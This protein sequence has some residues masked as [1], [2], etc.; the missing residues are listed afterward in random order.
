MTYLQELLATACTELFGVN[1][2][3]QLTRPEEQFG[4]FA[5]NVALQLAKELKQPPRQVAEQLKAYVDEHHN[6]SVAKVEVAGPGFLNVFMADEH[7][8]EVL[9]QATSATFGHNNE[10]RN[11]VV[12]AEYS[13]PN[14][15]KVLHA[16]HL[17]TTI[18]G[19]AIASL[20]QNAGAKVHRLNY[21]GDVGR[22]V[23]ITM[24]AIIQFLEG[25]HP[26]KLKTVPAD[27]RLEWLSA[28]YVEGNN[29]YEDDPAAKVAITDYNK[30]V[31]GLHTHND[32]QS[33]FAQIYWTCREW[34]YQGFDKLYEQLRVNP[35]EKY[36]PE[37][38]V[39]P[40]GVEMVEKG[41]KEG[42]F[43]KSE[44]AVVFKGEAHGLHTRVFMNSNGLP[45][46][47]AKDLG[48]AATKWQ[49]YHFDLSVIVTANDIVEYM[50]VVLKALSHFYPEVVERSK[51]LTHGV[52]K[53]PGGVKMSS[54]KG[55]I[56][57]AVDILEAAN[58]ANKV[59]NKQDN[60]E[61]VLAAVKYAF[62]KNRIGG[63]V[64]YDPAEAVALEGNSGPY[65]QYAHA[66]ARSI[67]K[68]G[69]QKPQAPT[70][71]EADERSLLRKISEY[72]AVVEN[73]TVELMPHHV[74][75][76][77]YELAQ[78]FNRFYEHNRVVGDPREAARLQLV[79]AYA[80][81]LQQ[82]LDLLN[83]PA[84]EKM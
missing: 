70:K 68:K 11:K 56:L 17:Y 62:L 84:P 80:H 61:T 18:V 83:I 51:H 7:F 75:T 78:T 43:E 46:Y 39:T 81:T 35:F 1:V 66:R 24:W 49:Q 27:E 58:E 59:A 65:L 38:E 44:G 64:I 16:G 50:K 82:G 45:L 26:N 10:Y 73:A 71:L 37:S 20:L 13:D 4:D 63:D 72:P 28:R 12:V 53:L 33:A 79:Q 57:R 54:R 55:N 23:G 5:S 34:S 41:L 15:F 67:L 47:E 30:R 3:P 36:I 77:L 48:L 42:V 40:L 14:P 9:K 2:E 6:G 76:Y 19:D 74:C 8:L 25:E 69:S 31:Y 21:G 60:P 22:H 52:I 32:H 29:A